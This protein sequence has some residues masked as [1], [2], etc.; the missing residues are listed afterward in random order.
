MNSKK[1][2]TYSTTAGLIGS[3]LV[4]GGVLAG[5]RQPADRPGREG[6]RGDRH[7]DHGGRRPRW[8]T[9]ISRNSPS[10]RLTGQYA[11]APSSPRRRGFGP[12]GASARRA[13]LADRGGG[14]LQ[15]VVPRFRDVHPRAAV[16]ARGDAADDIRLRPRTDD[17]QPAVCRPNQAGAGG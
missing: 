10:D 7:P 14:G 8:T 3:G 2:R 13:A 11:G 16:E 5:S 4:A 9:R 1:L 6:L 17:E 15:D 12:L